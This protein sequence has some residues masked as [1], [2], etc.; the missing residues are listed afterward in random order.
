[1]AISLERGQAQYRRELRAIVRG[2]WAGA[3]D[4]FDA[5][6]MFETA[7]R[8]SFTLAY[9][10]GAGDVGVLPAELTAIERAVRAG[11][12]AAELGYVDGFINAILRGTK[13][14]GVKLRAYNGRVGLWVGRYAEMYTLGQ[15]TARDDPK[16]AWVMDPEKENCPSCAK[17]NGQVRRK[18]VWDAHDLRPQS[19]HLECMRSAGGVTVCGCSFKKTEAPCSRGPLPRI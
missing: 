19:P 14:D 17:L 15:G 4:E 3:L 12:I 6:A 11:R 9:N 7:V 18:S 16:F 2:L 10:S 8:R 5:W 1:M 13:A